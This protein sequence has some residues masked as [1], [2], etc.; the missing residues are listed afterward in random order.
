MAVIR[1]KCFVICRVAYGPGYFF[2]AWEAEHVDL[3]FRHFRMLGLRV[4][5][6]L[7]AMRV[8]FLMLPARRAV[9]FGRKLGV[10]PFTTA[11]LPAV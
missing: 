2:L 3:R 5:V 10:C 11:F 4:Q 1:T 6:Q 9:M 8:A 7:P